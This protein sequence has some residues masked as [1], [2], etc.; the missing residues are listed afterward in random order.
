GRDGR[1][2][3]SH[4]PHGVRTHVDPRLDNYR[5]SDGLARRLVLEAHRYDD[6]VAFLDLRFYRFEHVIVGACECG[7]AQF[8]RDRESGAGEHKFPGHGR[9]LLMAVIGSAAIRG[10]SRTNLNASRKLTPARPAMEDVRGEEVGRGGCRSENG[11]RGSRTAT[12]YRRASGDTPAVKWGRNSQSISLR[13]PPLTRNRPRICHTDWL[14]ED[15]NRALARSPT[16]RRHLALSART[17]R[18]PQPAASPPTARSA[19]PIWCG[20]SPSL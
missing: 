1:E 14:W 15:S 7:A 20:R 16:F 3:G 13:M 12:R 4:V 19:S 5:I 10:S 18:H 8:G 2:R 6:I 17:Q 9:P 11:N